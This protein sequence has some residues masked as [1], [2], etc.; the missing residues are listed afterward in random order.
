MSK[1]NRHSPPPPP[2]VYASRKVKDNFAP[3]YVDMLESEQYQSLSSAQQAFYLAC[4]VQA[5]SEQGRRAIHKFCDREGK[6]YGTDLE[7]KSKLFFV[8][9]AS[10]MRR[11]GIDSGNGS[12][13]IKALI[14]RGFVEIVEANGHRHKMNIYR[15]SDR[16][17]K[18]TS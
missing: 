16:W 14:Q 8:F 7:D 5:V 9:P 17:K 12:R 6:S 11:F 18:Q 1:T 4:R 13:M 15:F 2:P 10:H 3:I